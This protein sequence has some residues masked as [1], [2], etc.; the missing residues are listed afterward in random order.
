M[1]NFPYSEADLDRIR[2]ETRKKQAQ[3]PRATAAHYDAATGLLHVEL[4]NGSSV[5]APARKLRGLKNAADSQ[6]ADVRIENGRALFWDDLDV[7]F[8]LIAA[9]AA[10]TGLTTTSESARRAGSVR[11]EAKAAAVR[12][13]GKKGGRPRKAAVV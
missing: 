11:S 8:S 10:M 1:G 9:L 5:A 13:N 4:R 12:E 3:Q 2:R 6:L 7:Q